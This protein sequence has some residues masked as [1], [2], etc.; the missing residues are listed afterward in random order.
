[1][2]KYGIVKLLH[3]VSDGHMDL[4]KKC[5]WNNVES[6]CEKLFI[7]HLSDYGWCFSFNPNIYLLLQ[8]GTMFGKH[9]ISHT[10]KSIGTMLALEYAA[11]SVNITI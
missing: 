9:S 4:V 6:K 2:A 8:S 10:N 5:W 1:M 3:D 7:D 11:C